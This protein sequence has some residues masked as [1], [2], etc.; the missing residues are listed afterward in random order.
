MNKWITRLA[1]AGK[2]GG[3]APTVRSRKLRHAGRFGG[4][5][6]P[7]Q[8]PRQQRSPGPSCRRPGRIGRKNAGGPPASDWCQ[9]T[10]V[11]GSSSSLPQSW[12]SPER[13]DRRPQS[14]GLFA[15]D[16]FIQIQ[17]G[18]GQERPGGSGWHVPLA[19]SGDR[20]RIQLAGS[21]PGSLI[22]QKSQ[23]DPLLVAAGRPHEHAANSWHCELRRC[24]PAP[25]SRA[26]SFA[27]STNTP[28]FSRARA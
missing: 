5:C 22:G 4:D 20:G 24:R 28:S 3:F 10:P 2:W 17:Q 14:A 19:G 23:Q 16:R 11:I 12:L 8:A 27:V 25:R 6:S 21:Q 9:K 18:P 26:Q 13:L 1:L 7:I 15:G